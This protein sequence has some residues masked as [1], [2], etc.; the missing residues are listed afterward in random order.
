MGTL[1]HDGCQEWS[2][3]GLKDESRDSYCGEA[4]VGEKITEAPVPGLVAA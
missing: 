2:W 3:G 4:R 1:V